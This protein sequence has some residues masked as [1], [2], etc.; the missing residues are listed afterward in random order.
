MG[1]RDEDT[2]KCRGHNKYRTDRMRAA[3][4]SR[5]SEEA[6]KPMRSKHKLVV[7]LHPTFISR[8]R[9]QSIDAIF[10]ANYKQLLDE[11]FVISGVNKVQIS[12]IGRAEGRG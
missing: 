8:R 2:A 6:S 10:Y 12:V 9:F 7:R 5:A 3:V 1:K 11:V 4:L